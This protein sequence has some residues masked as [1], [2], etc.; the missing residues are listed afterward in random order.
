[1][2]GQTRE[3]AGQG[4]A[5]AERTSEDGPEERGAWAI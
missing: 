4:A 1:M 5:Q 3:A 2:I